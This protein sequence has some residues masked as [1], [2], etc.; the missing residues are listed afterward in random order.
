MKLGEISRLI[1]IQKT[2]VRYGLDEIAFA[3]SVSRP[4]RMLFYIFP[5]NWFG[6]KHGPRGDRLRRALE[7]L[8]P[9]FIKFGQILSTRRDFLPED[10]SQE[11]SKLQDKV[12]PFPGKEARCIIEDAFEKKNDEIFLEFDET[13]IASASI[14][15]VHAA[16]MTDGREMIVKVVRPDIEEVIRRDLGLMYFLAEKAER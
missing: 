6:R 15:Q 8:G 10:V 12:P 9:I 11:F 16:K 14:A 2:L 13:P 7:D 1:T 3:S 5:W 4:V